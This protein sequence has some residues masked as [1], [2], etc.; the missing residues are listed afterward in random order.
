MSS[1]HLSFILYPRLILV[2]GP[3]ITVRRLMITDRNVWVTSSRQ[4][5]HSMTSSSSLKTSNW[6]TFF[7]FSQRSQPASTSH[8]GQLGYSRETSHPMIAVGIR[9]SI[10]P[11]TFPTKA[12]R[13]HRRANDCRLSV[14]DRRSSYSS[15]GGGGPTDKTSLRSRPPVAAPPAVRTRRYNP[16][17]P[18]RNLSPSA[19]VFPDGGV[20]SL[21]DDNR[22]PLSLPR[23]GD[24]IRVARRP[25]TT[26]ARHVVPIPHVRVPI[27]PT[28]SPLVTVG[29]ERDLFWPQRRHGGGDIVGE[30]G[31][32]SD[33]RGD[34][35][36]IRQGRI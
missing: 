13:S 15:H 8:E 25:A 2:L 9:S 22:G 21:S 35:G 28:L 10:R 24:L 17:P 4:V 3:V 18:R 20:P 23:H 36:V 7:S 29:M 11:R 16:T 14:W 27:L 12:P 33:G 1:A 31:G 26:T 34:E 30:G 5:C 32:R 6:F 19:M